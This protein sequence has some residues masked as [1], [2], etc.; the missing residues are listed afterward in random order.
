[1]NKLEFICRQLSR[2]ENKTFEHYVVTRIWH[3]LN[4]TDLKFITQQYV[5]RPE[6]RALTDMYFPQLHKH[7]EIDEGHHK[8]QIQSDKIREADI[9][10]A[11]GHEV[12][13]VDATQSLEGINLT[14]DNIVT[15]LKTAKINKVDFTPWDFEAEQNP[16]TYI[17]R[18]YIDLK[19]DVAFRTMV[20]AANCFGN[21]YKPK[22]I[23]TGGAK[24]PKESG[25]FIWFPKLYKN[26]RWNN[27]ISDDE[28]TITEIY[29]DEKIAQQHVQ[30]AIKDAHIKRI[31]FARVKSPLGDIM[32]RFKG[33][34]ELDLER[35]NSTSGIVLKRIN[36]RVRTY[37]AA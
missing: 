7:I 3:L 23:W 34:Y 19:D 17:S 8:M 13:R 35:T 22:G 30:K 11:T 6:G 29:L 27:S 32:Y 21:T 18:G 36:Q 28:N 1:M 25:K 5:V 15:Q 20:D 31:V 4:D 12:L 16:A 2:A 24:H 9:I 33:E 37:S 26:G 14:I 10:N